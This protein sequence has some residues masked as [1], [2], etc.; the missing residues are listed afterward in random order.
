MNRTMASYLGVVAVTLAAGIATVVPSVAAPAPARAPAESCAVTWGSQPKSAGNPEVGGTVTQI[1]AGRN[2]CYDR[3]VLDGASFGRA[4]YVDVVR[5]DGSG[6]VV[7]VRGGARL[8]ILTNSANGTQHG[9][10]LVD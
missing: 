1:R 3:L 8:A 6:A 5:A 7:P 9:S 10:E 2:E 4:Q